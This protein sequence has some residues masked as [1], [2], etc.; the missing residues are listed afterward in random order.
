MNR[1]NQARALCNELRKLWLEAHGNEREVVA[2]EIA[3]LTNRGAWSSLTELAET[4]GSD[5]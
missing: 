1:A 3:G 4:Q 5:G 2:R